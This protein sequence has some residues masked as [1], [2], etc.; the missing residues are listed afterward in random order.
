M[1]RRTSPLASVE[2]Q[3]DDAGHAHGADWRN[4]TRFVDRDG[5]AIV[6]LSK[7]LR[8]EL[9]HHLPFTALAVIATVLV[10]GFLSQRRAERWDAAQFEALHYAHLFAS[11][12]ATTA[13]FWRYRKDVLLAMGVGLVGS[14]VFCTA[15]DI[16]LPYVG[17]RLMGIRVAFELE[18]IEAPLWV[19]VSTLLGTAVGFI[20][21]KRLSVYSHSAHVFI[22][23]LASLMY[24]LT[25]TSQLWFRWA[26]APAVAFILLIAVFVP[27]CLSDLVMPVSCS[28]CGIRSPALRK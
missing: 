19:I 8:S 18:I 10:L 12:V 27:C 11:A 21:F 7:S 16:V 3:N 5:R 15:S 26:H 28:H 22:S 20:G 23:S 6:G 2:K 14:I 25:H 9:S 17:G 13:V 1:S 24:L 4:A